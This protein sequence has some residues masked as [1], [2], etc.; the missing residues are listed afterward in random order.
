MVKFDGTTWTVYTKEN[1]GLPSNN[2]KSGTIDHQGRLWVGTTAGVARFD[3]QTWTVYRS[4]NSE[5]PARKA[6]ALV[7]DSYGNMWMGTEIGLVVYREGGVILPGT[8]AAS[9]ITWGLIKASFKK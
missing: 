3:G 4:D 2:I 7:Q 9:S 8:T 1:S 6:Y 5:M